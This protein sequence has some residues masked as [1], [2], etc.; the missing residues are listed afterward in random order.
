M[1][2]KKKV[3]KLLCDVPIKY[4]TRGEHLKNIDFFFN[5]KFFT[6]KL[7]MNRENHGE[8][9]FHTKNL[10]NSTK[11]T[12]KTDFFVNKKKNREKNH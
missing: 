1:K 3:I 5:H 7:L 8:N 6:Q 12:E 10:F 4:R 11:N 2:N 9:T